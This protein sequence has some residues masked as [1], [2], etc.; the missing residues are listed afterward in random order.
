MMD[1]L[2]LL[3]STEGFPQRWHCG[4]WSDLHGWTHIASDVAI[5]G[6]Y[7]A[8]PAA[9]GYFALKRKDIPFLPIFWLFG[10][11][12]L[13]CGTGHL[14]EATLFWH[15]WYRF[16]GSMKVF[17]AIVSWGT[18]V[19]LIRILPQ[20]LDLPGLAR[21]N[22]DLRHEIEERRRVE[23]A[24]RGREAFESAV[25]RAS[26]DAIISIDHQGSVVG[27]NAAA[28]RIFGYS[29]EAATG[30]KLSTLIIPENLRGQ[31][32]QGVARFLQTG[33]KAV[34]GKLLELPA[35]RAD[36]REIQI[37]MFITAIE[38]D[39]TP[40]FTGF[41]RDITDRK[42]GE[43]QRAAALER[44][45]MLLREVHH[46]VKNNMQVISSL[47]R[48]HAGKLRDPQQRQVFS[49]CRDRIMS[50]SL[51]H[52]RLYTAGQFAQI[53][54][55]GY[56]TE[57]VRMILSTNTI[58]G[59]RVRLDM[60]VEPLEID[61]DAAVPLSLIASELLLNALKHAFPGNREG[62]L[63]VRLHKEDGVNELTVEDDGPGLPSDLFPEMGSGIGFE[64][65]ESLPADS[66][67]T[68][69]ADRAQ[70]RRDH[71]PMA[72]AISPIAKSNCVI[73]PRISAPNGE[74]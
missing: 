23:A 26:M 9:L 17:T 66:R 35:L 4:D 39:G 65:M 55:G 12:I 21:V 29:V 51:I 61:L 33:E 6:A 57:M 32:D 47:L 10:A 45:E 7:A 53:E 5:F 52:E 64:L 49:D 34:M 28:E 50:M 37:E 63:K 24:L 42:A 27:W 19:A 69:G 56:L 67:Q 3:F 62:V 58:T 38:T 2:R 46:R 8:I 72:G 31:H 43:A 73:H 40:L 20:A 60:Q 30:K 15:P 74:A 44:S 1:L 22:A 68:R 25:L 36:G 54:F 14:I 16:S 13:A 70:R 11:F 71:H 59:R 48:L 41:A 18:V